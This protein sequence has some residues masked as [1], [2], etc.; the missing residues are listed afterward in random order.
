[1][2]AA[3]RRADCN[4]LIVVIFKTMFELMKT[5]NVFLFKE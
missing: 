2:G 5:I 1:M 3:A 4:N